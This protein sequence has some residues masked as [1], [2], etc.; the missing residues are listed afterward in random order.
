MLHLALV[1]VLSGSLLSGSPDGDREKVKS[2]TQAP[3]AATPA[4]AVTSEAPA[5]VRA[6][7]T[8][9]YAFGRPADE[10]PIKLWVAYAFGEA[11]AP[12]YLPDGEEVPDAA[13]PGDISS[14]RLIVGAQLNVINFPAF[15]VGVGGQ[16]V[17]GQNKFQFSGGAGEQDSGF[18]LQQGKA[19]VSLRGRVLGI[20]GGYLF[21]LADDFS[22]NPADPNFDQNAFPLSDN[23]NAIQVGADFDYPSEVVRLFG[24]VDYFIRE[25]PDAAFMAQRPDQ[26]EGANIL[27][28]NMGAGVRFSFVELGAALHLRTVLK[29]GAVNESGGHVGTI[30]PYLKLAPPSLPVSLFVKGAV[31]DEYTDLGYAIGG[32]NDIKPSLGFTAG[33]TLGF[34]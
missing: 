27:L 7:T 21:D 30:A 32:A 5:D 31:L 24:G 8:D 6:I 19:F 20:H 23:R 22:P 2:N 17:A 33:L 13:D 3:E 34:N 9:T 14:Q 1:A 11:E 18:G 28:W 15:K 16:L 26:V 10:A 12:F 25:D 29:S 4:E